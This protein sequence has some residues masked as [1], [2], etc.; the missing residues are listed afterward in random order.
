[1][2]N[3]STRIRRCGV[4]LIEPR[5]E[6]ELDV[7]GL[8]TG[9]RAVRTRVKL[10][11]LAPHVGEEVEI[12]GAEAAA[13]GR[14]GETDWLA[15]ETLAGIERGVVDSLL[16]KGLLIGDG[17]EH[18][19]MRARDETVRGVHWRPLSAVSHAFSRWHE[20]GVDEDV[21]ITRHR[22]LTELIRESGEPPPHVTSR[23]APEHRRALPPARP[24]SID[25]ILA[26]RATCR[27]FDTTGT[28]DLARFGDVLKRVVGCQAEVE[29]LP[30]T[31]ALKKAHPSGGSLHP[32]EPYLVVQRVDGVAPGLYHYHVTEHALEPVATMAPDALRDFGMRCVAGQDFFADAH[33]LL[34]LAARFERTFWKYRNHPKAY[35]A[36]VLEAG[37]VSQNLYLSATELG[38]GAFV[39]AAINEVDIEEAFGL[40][41][42]RESPLAVLGFGPR[43]QQ[44]TMLEFDPLGEVW[45]GDA[46][47]AEDAPSR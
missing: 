33:A 14:I 8:L 15:R 10:V 20:A 5:E 29:I 35:R 4:V 13:L 9:T 42:L 37:H 23:A 31:K 46:L 32:L 2:T 11:A 28:L 41:A 43:A 39:T 40:D 30:G 25:A 3:T 24:T 12:D 21:R 36:I 47:R 19:S 1:M 26:R 16:E 27:N 7:A 17:D 34:I 18:A 38:L 22:T 6:A 45:D 44:K